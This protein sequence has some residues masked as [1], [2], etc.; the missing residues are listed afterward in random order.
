MLFIETFIE[1]F[2]KLTGKTKYKKI[3]TDESN[4]GEGF[5]ADNKILGFHQ[6]QQFYYLIIYY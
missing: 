2:W 4:K 3:T 6:S 5:M 1:F